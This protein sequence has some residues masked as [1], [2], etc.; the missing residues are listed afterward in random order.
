MGVYG[1]VRSSAVRAFAQVASK[2]DEKAVELIAQH[3]KD[4]DRGVRRAA[5]HAL[6][7]VASEGDT[8][9]FPVAIWEQC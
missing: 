4:G 9:V 3:L 2:G 6:H 7:K 5:V 1:S 8:K